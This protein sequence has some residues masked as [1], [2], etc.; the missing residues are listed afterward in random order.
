MRTTFL[1]D[2]FNLYHSL[3]DASRDLGFADGRGTKW[4]NLHSLLYAQLHL[5]TATG[6]SSLRMTPTLRRP[7]GRHDAFS[8]R[9]RSASGFR[10]GGPI[11]S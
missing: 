3:R 1:V 4:L 8:R 11:R 5:S 10:I 9:R 7:S 2:G 6:S